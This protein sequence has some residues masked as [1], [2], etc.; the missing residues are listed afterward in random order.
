MQRHAPV[1]SGGKKRVDEAFAL[2]RLEEGSREPGRLVGMP[3]SARLLEVSSPEYIVRRRAFAIVAEDAAWNRLEQRWVP[4]PLGPQRADLRRRHDCEVLRRS[5][6][7]IEE[8]AP[9]R[10]GLLPAKPLEEH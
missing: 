10:L 4:K 9:D 1:L 6:D 3:D 2:V 8:R 5:G 7:P